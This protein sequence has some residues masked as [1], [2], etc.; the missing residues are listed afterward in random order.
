MMFFRH[1][2]ALN[3]ALHKVPI[4]DPFYFCFSSMICPAL[5]HF[6][7]FYLL[8]MIQIFYRINH[9]YVTLFRVMNSELVKR[10]WFVNNRLSLNVSKTNYI[11]F[12]SH[13][14]HLPSNE[15]VITINNI[16]IPRVDKAR[17]LGVHI[18]QI[19]TWKAHISIVSSK[20]AKTLVFCL[21]L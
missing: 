4:L 2:E 17:F 15:G 6:F 12:R 14:K 20:V 21:G 3:L 11:L 10:N 18:D 13:R 9:N 1:T 5:S 16:S 8:L 19:L 7:I